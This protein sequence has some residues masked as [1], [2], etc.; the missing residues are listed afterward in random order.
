MRLLLAAPHRYPVYGP[1]GSGLHPKTYP[2]GSGYHLHDLLAKGLA[3][4]GHEVFYFL[5]KGHETEL[6][7]GVLPFEG[8]K[9]DV[10][11]Y[12]IPIGGVGFVEPATAAAAERGIP[13]LLTCHMKEGTR[14]AGPN[15]VFVSQALARAH[16]AER[17]VL[18]GIDPADFIF[19]ETKEDYFLFMGAMNKATDKGLGFALSLCRKAGVRLIVAGTALNYETIEYVA[20]LCQDAGA[21]Y[22]GDIRGARKAELLAGARAV[23]FPSRLPEGCPLVILEAMMS[24]TPA[25]SAPSGGAVE[26]VTPE[27]GILCDLEDD[28][29][30][31][32]DH[33]RTISSQSCREIAME[34]FHYLRMTDDY[35]REYSREREGFAG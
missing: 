3:E 17:V 32:L 24:G 7:A 21:E 25:I 11:L 8:W 14:R 1:A 16:D 9:N 13:C 29:T 33:I 10:E 2:S 27:T 20:G 26:I 35:L 28:W 23:L 22:L 15:W 12:H 18:N 5:A 34:K 30:V 31:A 6:P 4:R 19:S